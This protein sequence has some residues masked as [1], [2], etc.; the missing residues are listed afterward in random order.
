MLPSE[1]PLLDANLGESWVNASTLEA[2]YQYRKLLINLTNSNIVQIRSICLERGVPAQV[3][4]E[5]IA[6]K[7]NADL[8]FKAQQDGSL[9]QQNLPGVDIAKLSAELGET[10]WEARM[11][12]S[13][14]NIWG[15]IAR[16][17][18]E[19]QIIPQIE[20]LTEVL[21]VAMHYDLVKTKIPA[22]EPASQ[23]VYVD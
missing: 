3:L 14:A 15:E 4:D 6:A 23:D 19:G 17:T 10:V 12:Q 20:Q 22:I 5:A 7:N 21:K 8:F 11:H 1:L 2:F 13:L 16:A 9:S 18:A